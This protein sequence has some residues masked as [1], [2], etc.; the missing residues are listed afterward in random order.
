MAQIGNERRALAIKDKASRLS[1]SGEG[2]FHLALFSHL[3]DITISGNGK[4]VAVRVLGR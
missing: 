1:S 4:K 2:S 3:V